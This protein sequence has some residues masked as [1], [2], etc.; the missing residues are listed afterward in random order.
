MNIRMRPAILLLSLCLVTSSLVACV[1]LNKAKPNIA[2][3]DFG[4]SIPIESNQ[5]IVS[6]VFLSKPVAAE[7]LQQNKFRYRLNY[8]NPLRVFYY[9]ESRWAA[10]PAELFASKLSKMV[11]VANN[12][13]T[14]SLKLKIEAFDHVFQTSSVSEGFVQLNVSLVEIKS[15]KIISSQ[16]I[17]ENVAS[18]SPNAQ[19]GAAALQQASENMLKKVINW[20]NTI[21]DNNE[22]CR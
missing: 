1:S 18:A 8:Q 14:C 3:Y 22:L 7:S 19:G 5:Q 20:G 21:A 11:N 2:I 16:L 17:T 6:K 9:S 13:M 12:P 4:L 15:Q 10:T